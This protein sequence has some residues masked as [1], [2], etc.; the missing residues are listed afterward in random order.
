MEL[1]LSI[2]NTHVNVRQFFWGPRVLQCTLYKFLGP[3]RIPM[4]DKEIS[5]HFIP[6]TEIIGLPDSYQPFNVRHHNLILKM[7][8]YTQKSRGSCPR[9]HT[10]WAS[11]SQDGIQPS[12][13]PKSRLLQPLQDATLGQ[14]ES[15]RDKH[16]S[17]WQCMIIEIVIT[18]KR[19]RKER[20]GGEGGGRGKRQHLVL[21]SP[22]LHA[23]SYLPFIMPFHHH[24]N[25]LK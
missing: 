7:N 24:K 23:Q 16:C 8:K 18:F 22:L 12:L 4:L 10:Q 3:L 14:R 15:Q 2:K 17:I 1:D 6:C 5:F 19:W 11:V 25:P 13:I 9:T 20:G 21:K